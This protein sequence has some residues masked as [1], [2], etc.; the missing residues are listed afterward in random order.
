MWLWSKAVWLDDLSLL[1]AITCLSPSFKLIAG[2]ILQFNK[3]AFR[4]GELENINFL[5]GEDLQ[6]IL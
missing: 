6:I 1:E 2:H 3:V 5:C 4:K